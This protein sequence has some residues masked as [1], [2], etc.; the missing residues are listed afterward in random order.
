MTNAKLHA[1]VM[2]Y[3]Y[4][5]QEKEYEL[6]DV[7]GEV[8]TQFEPD[9]YNDEPLSDKYVLYQMRQQHALR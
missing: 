4:K 1:N 7:I 9:D 6:L 2:Q 8:M 3:A 5:F